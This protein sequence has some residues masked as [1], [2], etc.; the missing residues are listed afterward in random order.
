MDQSQRMDWVTFLTILKI[1][2]KLGGGKWKSCISRWRIQG[3]SFEGVPCRKKKLSTI[4]GATFLKLPPKVVPYFSIFFIFFSCIVIS[5]R[6]WTNSESF[7]R[8]KCLE[9][10]LIFLSVLMKERDQRTG[11]RGRT[12][13][14]QGQ[15]AIKGE[16]C[17]AVLG[18]QYGGGEAKAA[19]SCLKWLTYLD[20]DHFARTPPKI[21]FLFFYIMDPIFL[22]ALRRLREQNCS[23]KKKYFFESPI[24]RL[25]SS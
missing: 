23:T 24:K 7:A 3:K 10:K 18:G 19:K 14:A 11:V 17:T 4:D 22:M 2:S 15:S 6:F 20:I 13:C 12:P 21:F 16:V 5:S 1:F 9:Q 8:E 25:K